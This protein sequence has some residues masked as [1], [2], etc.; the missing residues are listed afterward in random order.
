[1]IYPIS[2]SSQQTFG[3]KHRLKTAWK[4]GLLP[5]VK[6]GI[7]GEP[8]TADTISI[9]HIK[10]RSQGGTN[11]WGNVFLADR[12]KNT[13]RGVEPI[14]QHVTC[15]MLRKYLLQFNGVKNRYIDGEA[16]KEAIRKTFKK[17]VDD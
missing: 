17:I 15:G 1:M 14:E 16:Y 3:Q 13:Q 8:L 10:P 4:K 5:N 11:A 9:E 7:Y 6:F 2:S 12:T